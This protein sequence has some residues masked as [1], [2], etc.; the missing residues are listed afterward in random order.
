MTAVGRSEL[1]AR[2]IARF[3]FVEPRSWYGFVV[4]MRSIGGVEI[5]YEGSTMAE[6]RHSMVSEGGSDT[7]LMDPF[8]APYSSLVC[9]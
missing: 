1:E 6:V 2:T 8:E 4:N 5:D 7:D 3:Q 9:T